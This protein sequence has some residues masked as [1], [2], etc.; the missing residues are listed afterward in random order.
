L[1]AKKRQLNHQDAQKH[2]SHLTWAL[3][4]F[5]TAEIVQQ[6]EGDRVAWVFRLR[7]AEPASK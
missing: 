3:D 5:D 6:T 7:T 2:F 4:L 1:L